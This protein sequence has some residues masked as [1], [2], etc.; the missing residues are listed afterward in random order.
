MKTPRDTR[1]RSAQIAAKGINTVV[2]VSLVASMAVPFTSTAYADEANT[3]NRKSTL[4]ASDALTKAI[5]GRLSFVRQTVYIPYGVNVD[6]W[7]MRQ[8]TRILQ[9]ESGKRFSIGE[10]SSLFES[11]TPALSYKGDSYPAGDLDNPTSISDE[12]RW[13]NLATDAPELELP[14][15]STLDIQM[16]QLVDG[17]INLPLV[18]DIVCSTMLTFEDEKGDASWR[19]EGSVSAGN[20]KLWVNQN[21][22]DAGEGVRVVASQSGQLE[23]TVSTSSIVDKDATF[24]NTNPVVVNSQGSI[25][26]KLPCDIET[27][28]VGTGKGVTLCKGQIVRL[29][30]ASDLHNPQ[31]GDIVVSDSSGNALDLAS[32]WIDGTRL[33]VGS[34]GLVITAPV[35]DDV[36]GEQAAD[37]VSGVAEAKL[38]VGEGEDAT[39]IEATSLEN[40]LA[41]FK[42]DI[43]TLGSEGVFDLSL[44]TMQVSDTAGNRSSKTLANAQPLADAGIRF[45]ELIDE[46]DPDN[47]PQASIVVSKVDKEEDGVQYVTSQTG[48]RLNF[49]VLDK[50]LADLLEKESWIDSEPMSY[51]VNDGQDNLIDPNTL[52]SLGGASNLYQSTQALDLVEEGRYQVEFDYTGATRYFIG[53][54]IGSFKDSASTDIIIDYTAPQVSGIELE[55]GFDESTELARS[56]DELSGGNAL[57]GPERTI[58]VDIA[59][60][61]G[62]SSSSD[63]ET[64]GFADAR[65]EWV[66]HDR[67]DGT[68]DG[69]AQS[70]DATR[71]ELRDGVLH[72]NLD[73]AGVYQLSDINLVL[74]DKAGNEITVNLAEF[75]STLPEGQRG[76]WD[77]S[78]IIVDDNENAQADLSITS[79]TDA[80]DRTGCVLHNGDVNVMA[81]IA[82]DPLAPVYAK[83]D[84]FAQGLSASMAP[85]DEG[86]L[87]EGLRM[88]ELAFNDDAQRWEL[89]I[90]LPQDDQGAIANGRY[91]LSFSYR[92]SKGETHT[93]VVDTNAPQLTDVE[94]EGAV[95]AANDIARIDGKNV[96]VGT[97]RPIRV[98]VQDLLSQTRECDKRDEQNTAGILAEHIDAEGKPTGDAV[99]TLGLSCTR[100][101]NPTD[102]P[103]QLEDQRLSVGDDGWATIEL[104]EAGVYDLSDIVFSLEDNAGN[105]ATISLADY[106]AALPAEEQALWGFDAIL[107]DSSETASKRSVTMELADAESTPASEDPDGFFHRGIVDVKVSIRDIWF[108]AYRSLTNRHEGFFAISCITDEGTALDVTQLP[109]LNPSDFAYDH[110]ADAWTATFRLCTATG[111][112]PEE[113]SYEIEI[114]YQGI[115]GKTENTCADTTFGIDYTAPE[116]GALTLSK[117]SPQQWG[118]LFPHDS[119]TMRV[120]VTDNYAGIEKEGAGMLYLPDNRTYMTDYENG[121]LAFEFDEDAERLN[122]DEAQIVVKDRAGNKRTLPSIESYSNT[123]IPANA[124]GFSVD[125]AAPNIE[126]SY[127]NDDVRN[128]RYYNAQRTATVTITE[129]NFDMLRAHDEKRVIA[130]ASCDGIEEE[131]TAKDFKN[132]SKD[133]KTWVASYTFERDGDWVFTASFTDPAGRA[134][135]TIRDEFTIDTTAPVLL[136]TFDNNEVQNG[137]YYKDRRTASI[138]VSERNFDTGL[139]SIDTTAEDGNAPTPAGWETDEH[140]RHVNSVHFGNETH[141]TL[142]V[143]VTDLAGNKAKVYEEPEFVIDLTAP[144][145]AIENVS[146]NTAYA[147]TVA[148]SIDY[149]DLNFDPLATTYELNG[150]R[151]G[152][153]F[154][155]AAHETQDETSKRIE[156][157]DFDRTVEFD[158]VY[159]L[160]AKV[161]DLAGNESTD[162]VRFSVNRFGSN[163]IL[164]GDSKS[165]PGSYLN[166]ARDLQ[167]AEINV[168]GLQ[169]GK[170]HAELVHD[171][172]TVQLSRGD[173][174]T[175]EEGTARGWSETLYTFPAKLFEEDGYYR[176]LL[177]SHDQA[178]NLS[179]N[180][181]PAKDE[182]REGTAEVNFAVD[183]T[184]PS[185]TITGIE[186]GGVYLQPN[187]QVEIDSRDNLAVRNARLLVDGTEVANWNSGNSLDIIAQHQLAS[188]GKPHKISLETTDRAGNTRTTDYDNVVVAGDWIAFI[189]N[190]P[191]LLYA[192]VASGIAL[193]AGIAI[194]AVMYARHRR[195]TE[196]IRNP[197]D[198]SKE[199]S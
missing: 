3:D 45:I 70:R 90:A 64:S 46:Q 84:A 182:K 85:E 129:A 80:V 110:A 108:E 65:I 31:I 173:D 123:N 56:L 132:P 63:A 76:A 122:F 130:T 119:E 61:P 34:S 187:M 168:S 101:L 151:K 1:S 29:P 30:V 183:T 174:Y 91:E 12:L 54:P 153:T 47:K 57:I 139:T 25:F 121:K 155:G 53:I 33:S 92:G 83:T 190:T 87:Q 161:S 180:T 27:T 184:S 156:F 88:G 17:G 5:Q 37:L 35:S 172:R 74:T 105:T 99:V 144:Q 107:V 20:T 42:L 103:E 28:E 55:G 193:I 77:F 78:T 24:A 152:M 191:E 163:Y 18:P 166:E 159:T 2:A 39:Y 117:T 115:S 23:A 38:R 81:W 179:Q 51:K 69:D 135:N 126:V 104:S 86:V 170:S 50:R 93:F 197:F 11:G 68:D 44:M 150:A 194:G 58:E 131:L 66:R 134:S 146:D 49:R 112:R 114:E 73:E 6:E 32:M 154:I 157:T 140:D 62:T 48:T 181:M 41:T 188:D 82:D 21:D 162:T 72:I 196:S 186:S 15:L 67:I 26:I 199:A 118:W 167:I 176:V 79:T 128:G 8:D 94:L 40:G 98:R 171:S 136:V 96:L 137:M 4:N 116:F 9:D 13:G 192:A 16:T 189:R 100:S 175:A 106:I 95:D 165:M 198:H 149:S 158:D 22:A 109:A 97:E 75:V 195:N 145:V 177:T 102:K 71:A 14:D 10:L 148:P 169:T 127:D 178:G 89:P 185:S 120:D 113:G 141:Y 7:L 125:A 133:G 124:V 111:G 60:L 143:S 36:Q 43:E 52:K 147:G 142:R 59:D 19:L 160:T 138:E 164:L